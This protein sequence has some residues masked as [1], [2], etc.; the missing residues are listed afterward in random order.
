MTCPY[1]DDTGTEACDNCGERFDHECHLDG[2]VY[3]PQP[4]RIPAL[5]HIE[6]GLDE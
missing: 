4:C 1:C 5:D 6:S 2:E 3:G